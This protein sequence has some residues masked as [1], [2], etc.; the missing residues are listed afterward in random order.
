MEKEDLLPVGNM[1][2]SESE[3]GDKTRE[4]ES[5]PVMKIDL[6]GKISET[7]EDIVVRRVTKQMQMK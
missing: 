6:V 1:I 7:W 4:S 5:E 2:E 3:P